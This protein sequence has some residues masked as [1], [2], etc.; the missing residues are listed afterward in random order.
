MSKKKQGAFL[1]ELQA[2]KQTA[3]SKPFDWSRPVSSPPPK[4]ESLGLTP[5]KKYSERNSQKKLMVGE[6]SEFRDKI[7]KED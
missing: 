6:V 4:P 1:N 3:P 2:K 7:R 5:N